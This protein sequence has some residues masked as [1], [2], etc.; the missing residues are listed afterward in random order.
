MK[1]SQR[2]SAI[3]LAIILAAI[4]IAGSGPVVPGALA[5]ETITIATL[6][7]APFSG[8]NLKHNG[9]VNHVITEA[10]KRKGY[11]VKFTYLPWK[12]AVTETNNGQYSA[13]SYV[14]SSIDREKEFLLSDPISDEKIVFFH[15][16][17]NQIQDWQTLADLK[18]YKIGATRGYTYT[19]GFWQAAESKQLKV[20]ITDS[21][22]QNF[23]KLFA[24]RI[25]LF[26][27]ALANGY[28]FLRKEFPLSKV[29]L[30][31][32]HPKPL[33]ETK[34]HLAFS[35]SRKNSA[36]LLQIFNQGLTEV[37]QAGLY[38]KLVRNLLDGKYQP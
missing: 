17:S 34:G 7:Y 19:H 9:F 15:L 25:D 20:E 38:D 2:A 14:Y 35:R 31:T 21:D 4:G 13:L 37:K 22:K 6:E 23:K 36:N 1:S 27:S 10:F 5:G 28:S 11:A 3:R 26:P 12:R 30:I 29:R 33:S 18:N 32:Y 8:K 16:K 24:G